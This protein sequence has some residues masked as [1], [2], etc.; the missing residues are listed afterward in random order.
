[1]YIQYSA[2]VTIYSLAPQAYIKW[3]N[4][5]KLWPFKCATNDGQCNNAKTK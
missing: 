5:T 3:N 1:M 4:N 2:V